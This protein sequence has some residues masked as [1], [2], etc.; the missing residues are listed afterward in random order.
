MIAH[1]EESIIESIKY[2]DITRANVFN[3][4]ALDQEAMCVLPSCYREDQ[5]IVHQIVLHWLY[6]RH[7]LLHCHYQEHH[8]H[9]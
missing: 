6:F 9:K 4:F 5:Q 7:L 3:T 2:W 1:H 8:Y